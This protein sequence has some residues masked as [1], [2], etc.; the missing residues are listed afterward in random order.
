LLGNVVNDFLLNDHAS[1]VI[2]ELPLRDAATKAMLDDLCEV[3]NSHSFSLLEH[4]T[5]VGYDDWEEN[6]DLVE[7]EYWWGIWGRRTLRVCEG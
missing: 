6:G 2:M 5:E 1:R 7:V 3:L 4:G